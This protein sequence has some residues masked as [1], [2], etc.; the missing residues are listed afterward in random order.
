MAGEVPDSELDE[1]EF[2]LKQHKVVSSP[3]G[4]DKQFKKI[5]DGVSVKENKQQKIDAQFAFAV[6]TVYVAA[7]NVYKPPYY[8]AHSEGFVHFPLNLRDDS[9]NTTHV[10]NIVLV[11]PRPLDQNKLSYS[12]AAVFKCDFGVDGQKDLYA[13]LGLAS[14]DAFNKYCESGGREARRQKAVAAAVE[15]FDDAVSAH[16][17]AMRKGKTLA[18]VIN[19]SSRLQ[20]NAWQQ[21][22]QDMQQALVK[23]TDAAQRLEPL[24]GA[25][26]K[27]GGVLNQWDTANTYVKEIEQAVAEATDLC[28][29]LLE[30]APGPSTQQ[31]TDTSTTIKSPDQHVRKVPAGTPVAPVCAAKQRS[32]R[33]SSTTTKSTGTGRGTKPPTQTPAPTPRPTATT[34]RLRKDEVPVNKRVLY[35]QSL[36]FNAH[37]RAEIMRDRLANLE[38]GSHSGGT[39]TKLDR[40]ATR[41]KLASLVSSTL[42]DRMQGKGLGLKTYDVPVAPNSTAWL[43]EALSGGFSCI[44]LGLTQD[45]LQQ[46][47]E[48]GEKSKAILQSAQL[49]VFQD[50]F[51]RK[52][53]DGDAPD[54]SS[55]AWGMDYGGGQRLQVLLRQN[56]PSAVSTN[57]Y[58][59]EFIAK[60][61]ITCQ[62][63]CKQPACGCRA[64]AGQLLGIESTLIDC[65]TGTGGRCLGLRKLKVQETTLLGHSSPSAVTDAGGQAVYPGMQ[66]VHSDHDIAQLIDMGGGKMP[67]VVF[68]PLQPR[69]IVVW[70]GSSRLMRTMGEFIA[71]GGSWEE[72]EECALGSAGFNWDPVFVTMQPG[73]AYMMHPMELHSGGGGDD[74]ADVAACLHV[75]MFHEGVAYLKGANTTWPVPTFAPKLADKLYGFIS[76][77]VTELEDRL[78]EEEAA[79]PSKRPRV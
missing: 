36:A 53:D 3:N 40:N 73:H 37:Q 52:P 22:Y 57:S 13:Q 67:M 8:S 5:I 41:K 17:T 29:P 38:G 25:S 77:D 23:G 44:S 47:Q 48:C 66:V 4:R 65:L 16:D 31:P 24:Y 51:V 58:T 7:R 14:V 45:Q 64:V 6:Y 50:M 60:Q 12:A 74:G 56:Y 15:A 21:L 28:Q 1:F 54:W 78:K 75:Y 18:K 34:R 71:N 63:I 39:Q 49:Q 42:A 70:R 69:T 33:S 30:S 9:T 59:A 11:V 46:W 19:G 68:V 61:P 27:D 72:A 2:A 55:A 20:P 62:C 26:N 79:H 35:L 32:A 10:E 43:F 76:A